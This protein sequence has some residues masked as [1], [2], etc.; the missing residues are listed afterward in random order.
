LPVDVHA[1]RVGLEALDRPAPTLLRQLG[2]AGQVA[3]DRAFERRFEEAP[4][5]VAGALLDLRGADARG[6]G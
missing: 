5:R 6:H 4:Q 3:G 1:E 2:L